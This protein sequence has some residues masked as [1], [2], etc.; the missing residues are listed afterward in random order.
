MR[1]AASLLVAMLMV[2][3]PPA[4]RRAQAEKP[5]LATVR[6]D[7]TVVAFWAS[8]CPPCLMELPHLEALQARLPAGARVVAVSVDR[9][10]KQAAARKVFAD[11]KLTL[12]LVVG[13]GALYERYFK[14]P[15]LVIP[16]MVV[17]DRRDHGLQSDG[18]QPDATEEQFIAEVLRAVAVVSDAGGK[19]PEGWR[20]LR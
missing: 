12:P 15:E 5:P 10:A 8:W 17:I 9:G 11:K 16:R 4:W 20:P 14:R 6:G 18:F 7:I 1:G 3:S 2:A 19:P 13:G